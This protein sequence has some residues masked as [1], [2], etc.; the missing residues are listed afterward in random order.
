MYLEQQFVTLND[1]FVRA[2]VISKQNV[3]GPDVMQMI[4]TMSGKEFDDRPE[5]P[6]ELEHLCEC[7]EIS[8]SKLRK[9]D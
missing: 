4:A 6:R 3:V 1:G 8:S 9:K 7:I 5:K 2:T